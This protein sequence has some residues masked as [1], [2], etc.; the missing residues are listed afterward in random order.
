MT[1]TQQREKLIVR[2]TELHTILYGTEAVCGPDIT[3]GDLA[4]WVE[5]L[6]DMALSHI[7][8]A[9]FLMNSPEEFLVRHK[10]FAVWN[11]TKFVRSMPQNVKHKAGQGMGP[12]LVLFGHAYCLYAS[13]PSSSIFR[14]AFSN[15]ISTRAS[16]NQLLQG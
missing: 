1:P 10:A 11:E 2:L 15:F 7:A 6:I 8:P 16:K 9:R 12:Y 5:D 4:D 13:P 3:D 14:S